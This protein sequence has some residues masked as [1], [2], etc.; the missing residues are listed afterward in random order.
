[1][2]LGATGRPKAREAKEKKIKGVTEKE[3]IKDRLGKWV[4]SLNSP[5]GASRGPHYH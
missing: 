4:L 3:E 1:M 2:P 5:L